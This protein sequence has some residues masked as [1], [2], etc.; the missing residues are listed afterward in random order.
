MTDAAAIWR[1]KQEA[2]T[3]LLMEREK[4]AQEALDASRVALTG[5][6][7]DRAKARVDVRRARR[8]ALEEAETVGV[9]LDLP[10]L[11]WADGTTEGDPA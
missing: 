6:Q 9:A 10:P 3:T 5:L 4:Q 2:Y 8:K 1:E 11:T 7:Q